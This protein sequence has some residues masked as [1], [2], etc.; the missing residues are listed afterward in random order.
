VYEGACAPEE[1]QLEVAPEGDFGSPE[2]LAATVAG[3][4]SSWAPE[5]DL[6]AATRFEWRVAARLGAALG[7][8][9]VRQVFFTGPVCA[10]ADLQAPV[11]LSPA[12]EDVVA[13]ASPT[14]VWSS[15][16]EACLQEAYNFEV[17]ADPA[18]GSAA[19]SGSA[20]PSASFETEVDFLEDCTPYFWRVRAV[21]GEDMSSPYSTVGV[22]L[23]DFLGACP[24]HD[25][26]PRL[27][28]VVWDDQ[29]AS[30]GVIPGQAPPPAGCVYRE[31]AY[32]G[33]GVRQPAEPGIAGVTIRYAAGPCPARGEG[34]AVWEV[35]GADGGYA[36]VLTPGV[37]CFWLDPAGDGNSDALGDGLFTYPPGGYD[38]PVNHEVEVD[39]G[40]VLDDL[41]FGWDAR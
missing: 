12:Q 40:D 29:C 20:G 26:L 39:W 2:T 14:L 33:D 22:F 11:L 9:S 10:G 41:D 8:Y 24:S 7:P 23:T 13:D 6:A 19:L 27:S 34:N 4:D 21:F 3:G 31:G 1:F 16:A 30:A 32:G 25:S 28:G 17:A 15:A 18:F 35:T 37:Y 38:A 5:A 36:Y